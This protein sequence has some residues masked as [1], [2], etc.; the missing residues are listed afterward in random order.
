MRWRARI[1]HWLGAVILIALAGG[2]LWVALNHAARA[3]GS[4]PA[5]VLGEAMSKAA[6]QRELTP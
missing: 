6:R 5:A 4:S 2:L 1:R 3:A